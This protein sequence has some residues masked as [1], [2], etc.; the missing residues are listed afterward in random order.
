MLAEAPTSP[1]AAW[2]I[3]PH[4]RVSGRYIGTG[5]REHIGRVFRA[6]HKLGLPRFEGVQ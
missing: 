1:P 2:K 3:R 5:K 4:R 6:N